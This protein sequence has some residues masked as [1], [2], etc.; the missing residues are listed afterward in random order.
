DTSAF[1]SEE[2]ER[3]IARGVLRRFRRSD[4]PGTK[5]SLGG[6]DVGNLQSNVERWGRRFACPEDFDELIVAH[7]VKSRAITSLESLLQTQHSRIV[8]VRPIRIAYTESD[9]RDALDR[10]RLAK[11]GAHAGRHYQ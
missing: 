10:Q 1:G 2:G 7:L 3:E 8:S 11:A 6:G 4:P 9:V 5:H